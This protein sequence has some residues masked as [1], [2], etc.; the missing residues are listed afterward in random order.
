MQAVRMPGIDCQDLMIEAFG[1]SQLS[2]LMIA[3]SRVEDRLN[4]CCRDSRLDRY[5]LRLRSTLFSVHRDC[6][7]SFPKICRLLDDYTRLRTSTA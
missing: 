6:S 2:D 7:A 1:V 5:C 3:K 4:I